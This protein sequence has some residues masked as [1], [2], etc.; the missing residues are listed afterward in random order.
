MSNERFCTMTPLRRTSSG[1]RGSAICTRLF[2][3]KTDWSTLVPGSK[4]AVIC[5]EPLDD[6]V[7]LKYESFSTPESCPSIG[8]ATVRATASA[9]AAGD[10]VAISTHRGALTGHPA[11]G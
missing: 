3:L 8:A 4:V 10:E 5:S 6:E 2:T 11:T 7:E 1:R 9:R